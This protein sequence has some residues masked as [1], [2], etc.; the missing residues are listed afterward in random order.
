MYSNCKQHW[1]LRKFVSRNLGSLVRCMVCWHTGTNHSIQEDPGGLGYLSFQG[2]QEA[3]EDL[4]NLWTLV[5]LFWI[6]LEDLGDQ[7]A[8][9][10]LG[11]LCPFHPSLLAGLVPQEVPACLAC[12]GSRAAPQAPVLL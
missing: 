11:S 3:Q 1:R 5:D 9:E 6:L 7:A 8:L 10:L 12:P 2:D 4:L